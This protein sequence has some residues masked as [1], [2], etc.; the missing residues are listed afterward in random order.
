LNRGKWVDWGI[1]LDCVGWIGIGIE[2]DL[3]GFGI[4]GDV[5]VL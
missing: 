2:T 5:C 3:V 4:L 1:V